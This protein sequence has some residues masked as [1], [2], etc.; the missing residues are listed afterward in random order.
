M[1]IE[2]EK[3]IKLVQTT[4]QVFKLFICMWICPALVNAEMLS[5]QAGPGACG[6]SFRRDPGVPNRG[7]ILEVGSVETPTRQGGRQLESSR[8]GEVPSHIDAARGGGL[9]RIDHGFWVWVSR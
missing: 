5:R 4:I 1:F 9:P 6:C 3:K 2:S 7:Q 8:G